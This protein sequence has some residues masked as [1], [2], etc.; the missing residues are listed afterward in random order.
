M[1]RTFKIRKMWKVVRVAEQG[2]LTRREVFEVELATYPDTP[3]GKK[4]AEAF[5]A[6][7]RGS[8]VTRGTERVYD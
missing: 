3:V 1:G 6:S 5:A 7:N 4:L 2:S 8:F